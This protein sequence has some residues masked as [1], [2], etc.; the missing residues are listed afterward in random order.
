MDPRLKPSLSLARSRPRQD[1][2]L[3]RTQPRQTLALALAR[4]LTLTL[5]RR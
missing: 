1:L 4:I 2:T 5:T 3:A